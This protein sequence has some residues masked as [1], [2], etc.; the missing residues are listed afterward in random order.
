MKG[1]GACLASFPILS[2]PYVAVISK[3][4]HRSLEKTEK[5]ESVVLKAPQKGKLDFFFSGG[6][7]TEV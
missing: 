3:G 2:V 6:R 7:R 4:Q 5:V 1:T